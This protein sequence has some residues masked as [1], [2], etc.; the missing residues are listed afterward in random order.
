DGDAPGHA[1]R[2][3]VAD[4]LVLAGLVE[5]QLEGVALLHAAGRPGGEVGSGAGRLV[6]VVRNRLVVREGDRLAGLHADV[7]RV[8][9]DVLH[10]HLGTAAAT[11]AIA[12][13]LLARARAA[14]AAA[15]VVVITAAAGRDEA[16]GETGK[17][18]REELGHAGESRCSSRAF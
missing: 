3:H 17:D 7:L 8:E 9:L 1:G 6:H 14:P 16:E 15:I 2:V 12:G 13:R 11:A 4:V 18:Q 10:R 5:R